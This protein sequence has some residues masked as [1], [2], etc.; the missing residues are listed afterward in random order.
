[1]SQVNVDPPAKF[2]LAP[3]TATGLG[4]M[5]GT[6]VRESLSVVFGELADLPFLPE[7]P[8][9]GPGGDMIGRA[10]T[11]LAGLHGDVQPSGWRLTDGPGADERRGRS[12][13]EQ[14]LDVLEE[15]TQGYVGPLKVQVCGPLTL[16]S[17]VELP[18][19]DKLLADPGARRDVAQS[20][21]QGVSEHVQA[22]RRRVPCAS[23]ILQVDEPMLAVALAGRVRTASGF[24]VLRAIE[25][26][27]VS[28]SL[29]ALMAA[30]DV[31]V[32]VHC[33]AP[34]API[35]LLT[36]LG[37]AGLSLDLSLLGQTDDDAL[38]ELIEAGTQLWAGLVDARSAQLSAV[39]TTVSPV[40][41]VW[42][43]LG[44]TA[45][46][47]ADSVVV[48]PTCGLAGVSPARARAVLSACRSAG[49]VLRDDPE[50]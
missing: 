29:Q 43:R 8:A 22:L 18:R 12:W 33:C 20:L 31:D 49:K 38:G 35:E 50:S 17:T 16:A 47:L 19:G 36:S 44:F 21:A 27:E 39:A 14:D 10:V 32:V 1:M 30:A 26:A 5:P 45:E 37:L 23:L 9:R 24:G 48:T 15:L 4:S 41:G 28:S 11:M 2:V 42:N 3:G 6:D 34:D 7:H 40:K 13:L 46:Q 25:A